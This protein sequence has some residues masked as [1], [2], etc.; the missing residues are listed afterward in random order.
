MIRFNKVV[1]VSLLLFVTILSFSLLSLQFNLDFTMVKFY[2]MVSHYDSNNQE[3]VLLMSRLARILV[4]LLV[5]ASLS[6][7]G[8]LMQ[9][10]YQNDLADPS[11]MGISE[12]SALAISLM[13]IF[14]PEAS[15]LEKIC[16][17]LV[18]SVL[19]SILL[20]FISKKL[21]NN[22]NRLGLPLLGIVLSMLLSSATTFIVSYFNIAQSVSAWY[23]SRLYRVSLVDVWYF[24]PFLIMGIFFLV[25][26]RKELNIFAFG[27]DITT[28]IGMNRKMVSLLLSGLVVLFT[29]VSVAVVGRLAFI[30]LVVPHISKLLIGKKYSDNI[31]LVPML[32][33]SLVLVSDYLSRLVNAP[34]E[35][36]VSVVIAMIGVPLFLYLIRKGNTFSY[37]T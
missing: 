13:M 24:L 30:G 25:I 23:A 10:Q 31:L 18:G 35:T 22:Q 3:H 5:G 26:L 32:G 16:L 6:L 7:S 34:F 19:T 2:D 20:S 14:R 37:D 11:L 8:L 36:P 9:L 4:A 21:I 12:G 28:V 29:G 17:S 1:G 15:M 33:A 27:Q